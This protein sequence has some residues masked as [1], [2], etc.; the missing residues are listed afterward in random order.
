[1]RRL[2]PIAVAV[3]LSACSDDSS[4]AV[5]SP[6]GLFAP[7]TLDFGT[8]VVGVSHELTAEMTNPNVGDLRVRDVRFEPAV[9]V[10][11]ARVGERTLKGAVLTSGARAEVRVLF[12]PR[13]EV[14]Y[15]AQMFVEFTEFAV[16]LQLTGQGRRVLDAE[17]TVTP[18]SLA[19]V[20]TELG[21]D[22]VQ[23]I[24]IENV[25]DLTSQIADVR[26][27]S[28]TRPATP[29]TSSFFITHS[30]T[31]EVL[32]D[33]TIEAK[34]RLDADVHFSPRMAGALSDSLELVLVTGRSTS[35][36]VSGTGL[37]AGDLDCA[38]ERIDFGPVTRGAFSDLALLCTA[39]DGFFTIERIGMV[40]GTPQQFTITSAPPAGTSIASGNSFE[41]TLRFDADG[42]PV[43][44]QGGLEIA[45]A[46]GRTKMI[47]LAAEVVPPHPSNTALT[48]RLQWD[49]VTT[50][51][52]LHLVRDGEEPYDPLN[53]CFFRVKNPDWGTPTYSEDDP[54]LDRDDID[55]QGP[56]EVNLAV[57]R[58][59]NY[60]IYV[61]YYRAPTD[62]PTD[63]TVEVLFRG[64]VALVRQSSFP[65]CGD[66]WHVARVH[67]D[68]GSGS[69]RVVD[70]RG[71]S[72]PQS[73]CDE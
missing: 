47:E 7:A 24:Q 72:R 6:E 18:D 50:D 66:M 64:Q 48:V 29:D 25:G 34:A 56:E 30:G 70:T 5:I 32:K 3:L 19:F 46:H 73:R 9:D 28:I 53:D 23:P 71:D 11:A 51:F 40:M 35:V 2:G 65:R 39:V 45:A 33:V 41:M 8:R 58:E 21:R 20:G 38:P 68:Q 16:P 61:H 60:D 22:I 52:D 31:D 17:L 14:D 44:Q 55:G 67:F 43:T 49:T 27:R 54:F 62:I 12:A 4:L 59:A 13:D 36:P 26:L 37:A 42:L 10:Y 15:S 69:V 57:A 63:A 1:M